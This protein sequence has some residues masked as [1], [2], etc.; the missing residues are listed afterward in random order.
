MEAPGRK[1][2]LKDGSVTFASIKAKTI[3]I[4][5]ELIDI[6]NDD[7]NGWRQLLA[8]PGEKSV[9]IGFDGVSKDNVFK[10]KVS[11]STDV[12]YAPLTIEFPDGSTIIGTFM[13][14]NLANTGSYKDAI[15]FTGSMKSS[16][17][18]VFSWL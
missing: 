13:L 8:E 18:Q 11:S 16:G 9:D 3:T 2:L 7:S 12:S 6:S 5:N 17:T 10:E 4:N 1:L 15:T 14:E